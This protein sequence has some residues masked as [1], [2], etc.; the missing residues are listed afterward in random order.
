MYKKPVMK[1]YNQEYQSSKLFAPSSMCLSCLGKQKQCE[2]CS[3]Q[4]LSIS[5]LKANDALQRIHL[6][7]FDKAGEGFLTA[8]QLKAYLRQLMLELPG[9]FSVGSRIPVEHY[10]TI[11]SRKFIMQ[12]L[13]NGR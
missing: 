11:A 10:V 3:V 2:G 13:K 1:A 6:S 7:Y 9:L 12:H 5:C 8:E 4:V